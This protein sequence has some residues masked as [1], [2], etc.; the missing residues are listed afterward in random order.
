M[1]I[2]D[3]SISLANCCV[4]NPG[5]RTPVITYAER[6]DSRAPIDE[7][8]EMGTHDGTHMDAPWHYYPT[9]DADLH[10]GEGILAATIDQFPLAYGYG[11]LV[12][13]D[14]SDYPDGHLLLVD[15]FKYKLEQWNYTLK[16]GDVVFIQ[17]GAAPYW[18]KDSH[19]FAKG[20][21]VSRAA[22]IWLCEQGVH[23]VG[24][25]G[26]S[27]D[28]PIPFQVA[29]FSVTHDKSILWEGHRAGANRGYYQ[30]EKLTNLNQVPNL[31]AKVFCHPISIENCSAAYCR[32]V[33]VVEEGDQ[34]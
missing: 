27:W 5:G 11:D 20:V 17:C 30:I 16:E 10:G 8:I 22:T 33:A 25:D 12:M 28:R 23:V 31:G 14:F 1:K 3:L 18:N 19:Y 24:T 29:E 13:F 6:D 32:V 26:W 4:G 2:I 34:K 21:G 9:M 15:D 7:I